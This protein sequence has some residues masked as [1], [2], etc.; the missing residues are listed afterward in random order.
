MIIRFQELKH[1]SS[2]SSIAIPELSLSHP[3]QFSYFDPESKNYKTAQSK[4]LTVYCFSVQPIRKAKK[5]QLIFK[6]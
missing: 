3:V 1:T 5:D 6:R 2:L 4:E